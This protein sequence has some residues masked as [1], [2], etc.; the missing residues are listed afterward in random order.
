MRFKSLDER[1]AEALRV[2]RLVKHHSSGDWDYSSTNWELDEAQYVSAPSSLSVLEIGGVYL[3]ALVKTTT[4]PIANVKEG[5]LETYFRHNHEGVHNKVDFIFRY[6]DADNC[7]YLF[8]RMYDGIDGSLQVYRVKAGVPTLLDH[9]D[10]ASFAVNT[11]FRYRVTWWNDYV[12]LVIRVEK[13]S[14][15][16]WVTEFDAYDSE[17]NWKDIGGRVGAASSRFEDPYHVWIDD[18]KIYG[19]PP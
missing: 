6:Q 15:G 2:S 8:I 16:E 9:K 3:T 7:Y 18:T 5:R 10:V 4:V 14:A 13:Y 1:I 11:W 17:N 12:G 19:I